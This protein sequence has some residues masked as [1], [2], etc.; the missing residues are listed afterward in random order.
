M[1]VTMYVIDLKLSVCTVKVLIEGSVSQIFDL[2]DK[3][4]GGVPPGRALPQLCLKHK[5]YQRH[6]PDNT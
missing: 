5:E 6:Q 1:S 3:R 4:R 2:V